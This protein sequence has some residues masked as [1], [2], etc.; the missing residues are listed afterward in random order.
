[1]LRWIRAWFHRRTRRRAPALPLPPRKQTT[2][3]I[4]VIPPSSVTL[5]D[6]DEIVPPVAD[7]AILDPLEIQ[8]LENTLVEEIAHRKLSLPPFPAT[9]ARVFELVDQPEIDLNKLVTALHWEP[10]IAAEIMRLANSARFGRKT[11]DLRSACLT[12]GMAELSSIV[13][14]VTA[15]SLFEVESKMEY[16]L[17]PDLWAAAYRESLSEAFAASWLAQWKAI[18]RPDRVF[19]RTILEGVARALALRALAAM[20]LEGKQAMPSPEVIT[21]A[22]DGIQPRVAEFVLARWSLPDSIATATDPSAETERNIVAT[23]RTLVELQ[24]TANRDPVAA[25]FGILSR[26]IFL[27]SKMLRNLV[28]ELDAAHGRV[29]EMLDGS[30]KAALA[31]LK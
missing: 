15:E 2:R 31:A 26:A 12:L 30:P 16:D 7:L 24:R 20:I 21:L 29:S 25:R 8:A 22:I 10:A 9:A 23:V 18:S 3:A 19:L 13:A 28:K 17:Y 5:D 14:G 1:M 6:L 4:P 11:D 27:D